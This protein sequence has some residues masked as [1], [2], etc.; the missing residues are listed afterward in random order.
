CA[1]TCLGSGCYALWYF[2]LW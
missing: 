2:D 1:R